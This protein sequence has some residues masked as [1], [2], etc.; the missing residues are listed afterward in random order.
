MGKVNKD[1]PADSHGQFELG[2]DQN[3]NPN[4]AS[5]KTKKVD[6]SDQTIDNKNDLKVHK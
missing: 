1:N 3:L 4:S 2:Y 6:D 5:Y